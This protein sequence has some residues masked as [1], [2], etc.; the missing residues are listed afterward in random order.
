MVYYYC[1]VSFLLYSDTNIATVASFRVQPT[2][3]DWLLPFPAD[4]VLVVELP[5][6]QLDLAR[7]C[8]VTDQ[9]K[10]ELCLLHIFC[11]LIHNAVVPS[12]QLRHGSLS[13]TPASQSWPTL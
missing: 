6:L 4:V 10:Q 1:H 2:P 7:L 13:G 11:F 8:D 9:W 12:S 5:F 3:D